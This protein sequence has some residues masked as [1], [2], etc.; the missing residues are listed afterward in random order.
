MKHRKAAA[1]LRQ[2]AWALAPILLTAAS[3]TAMVCPMSSPAMVTIGVSA[4]RSAC[5]TITRRS[6]TPFARAVRM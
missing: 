4:F 5:R 1:C 3:F 2:A 6:L